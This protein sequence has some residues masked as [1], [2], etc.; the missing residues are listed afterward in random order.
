MPFS[1]VCLTMA[2]RGNGWDASALAAK[3]R[4]EDPP[5]W[6]MDHAAAA[7]QL[8]LELVPLRQGEMQTIIDRLAGLADTERLS[9]SEN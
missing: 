6:L 3:L 7:G 9:Q 2:T 4:E 8:F 1:R 5:I